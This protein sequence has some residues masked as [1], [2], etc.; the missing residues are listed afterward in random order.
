MTLSE[1]KAEYNELRVL[2]QQG[3][4]LALVKDR[5]AQLYLEVCR[6]SLRECNCK[7]I[8]DDAMMEIYAK[9]KYY[10]KNMDEYKTQARLVNGVVLQVDGKHYTNH[11]LTDEVARKFLEA[12]PMRKSWFAVLPSASTDKQVTAEVAEMPSKGEKTEKQP[13]APKNKKTSVKR[14]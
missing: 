3:T 14:K 13:T 9:L 7:N 5:I 1:A 4:A 10:E 12:F 6:K 11:N 8:L 2:A